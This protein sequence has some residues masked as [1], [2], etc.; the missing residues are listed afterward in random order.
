M[1]GIHQSLTF[2]TQELTKAITNT[3]AIKNPSC[4]SYQFSSGVLQ[5]PLGV[6][7][8]YQILAMLLN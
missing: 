3:F 8:I 6:D 4:L 5:S 1:N 2:T 7:F